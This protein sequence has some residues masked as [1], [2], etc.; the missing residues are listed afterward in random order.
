M[1]KTPD[2]ISGIPLQRVAG[3]IMV[4]DTPKG[5]KIPWSHPAFARYLTF[6]LGLRLMHSSRPRVFAS[7]DIPAESIIEVSPALVLDPKDQEVIRKTQL[8]HY[9]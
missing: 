9:T 2:D 1:A 5:S 8:D 6:L 3:L 4:L 7:S